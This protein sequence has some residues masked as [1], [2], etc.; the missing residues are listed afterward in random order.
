VAVTG[1][2]ETLDQAWG[3]GDLSTTPRAAVVGTL[4]NG[5]AGAAD[6]AWYSFSLDA[7]AAVVLTTP[8]S[9]VPG[10]ATTVL[11]LYKQRPVRLHGPL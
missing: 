7:P 11:G 8:D 1:A 9:Q 5:P 6:V 4:G 3:L 10:A 2:H